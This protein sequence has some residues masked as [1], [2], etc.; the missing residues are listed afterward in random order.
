VSAWAV[1]GKG[2]TLTVAFTVI[3]KFRVA[4]FKLFEHFRLEKQQGNCSQQQKP[5]EKT[6]TNF[7]K[8]LRHPISSALIADA[9]PTKRTFGH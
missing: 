4:C 1:P 5:P 9:V 2:L 7:A 3:I 6:P 8:D